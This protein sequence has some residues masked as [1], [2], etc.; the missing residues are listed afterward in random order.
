MT[1]MNEAAVALADLVTL[2][3]AKKNLSEK[4]YKRQKAD[5]WE[6]AEEV[7]RQGREENAAAAPESVGGATITHRPDVAYVEGSAGETGLAVI[8]LNAA[9]RNHLIGLLSAAQAGTDP[10][11]DGILH[12]LEA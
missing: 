12:K 11:G 4:D 6:R 8:N 3:K 1:V 10:I 2:R 5:L 9:E 7:V